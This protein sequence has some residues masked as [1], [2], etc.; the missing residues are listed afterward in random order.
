[1]RRLRAA[2]GPAAELEPLWQR[3][4]ERGTLRSGLRKLGAAL[5]DQ[6]SAELSLRSLQLAADTGA[7][8]IDVT[9][10][11]AFKS[12]VNQVLNQEA[13]K[14]QVLDAINKLQGAE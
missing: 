5:G 1:M 7:L 6:P 2:F 13:I 9:I 4:A 10:A 8:S 12:I 11:S 14:R 3:A